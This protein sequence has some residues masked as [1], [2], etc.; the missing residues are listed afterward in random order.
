MIPS[1]L[2]L[3]AVLAFSPGCSFF[4]GPTR[5]EPAELVVERTPERIARGEYLANGV[6]GC[7]HCHSRRDME[8]FALPIQEGTHGGGGDCFGEEMGLPGT[9]CGANISSSKTAGLGAW[10][11]GEILRAIRE[12]IGRDGRALFPMMPYS[13]YRHMD[14]EDAYSIVAYLR[15]L[16]AIDKPAP[17]SEYN[18]LITGVINS[19]PEPVEGPVR[20]PSRED[21]AA[22][23]KYLSSLSGCAHCHTPRSGLGFDEDRWMAGGVETKI[24]GVMHVVSANITPHETG[25]GRYSREEFISL[26]KA[27]EDASV[28][29]VEVP[30]ANRTMMPWTEYAKMTEE[31]L[32]AIYDYLRS[33]KP[34]ENKVERWPSAAA[35]GATQG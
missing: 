33:V 29:A 7:V 27:Y 21:T 24:D 17:R 30:V 15:T 2:L 34:I 26:F 13:D 35:A 4:L 9:I 12:G 3:I 28:V 14:D 19:F 18:F 23:G 8:R 22:Y 32:G 11:D 1:R 10:T 20:A 5:S 25:I 31:D 6:A 16:P